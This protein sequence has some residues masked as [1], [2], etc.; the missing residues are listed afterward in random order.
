MTTPLTLY[1]YKSNQSVIEVI[2][3]QWLRNIFYLG[4]ELSLVMVLK[5]FHASLEGDFS[6]LIRSIKQ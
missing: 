1:L 2:R 3:L 6:F 4:M 5:V